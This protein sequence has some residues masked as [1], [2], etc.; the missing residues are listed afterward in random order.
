VGITC[1]TTFIN[2]SFLTLDKNL[3]FHPFIL[4]QIRPF[5]EEKDVIRD[6][7]TIDDTPRYFSKQ[8]IEVTCAKLTRCSLAAYGMFLLN[9]KEVLSLFNFALKPSHMTPEVLGSFPTLEHWLY[10]K[11]ALSSAKKRWLIFG[12]PLK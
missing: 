5:I 1:S 4:S 11:R 12:P 6:L 8:L 7:P 9:N 2:T 10:K 3:S